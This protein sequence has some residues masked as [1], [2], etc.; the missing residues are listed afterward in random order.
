MI[1]KVSYEVGYVCLVIVD[2]RRNILAGKVN[3]N[4]KIFR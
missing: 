3:N 1:I 4:A 2:V